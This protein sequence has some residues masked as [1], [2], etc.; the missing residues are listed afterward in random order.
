M[1]NGKRRRKKLFFFFF[2]FF[3]SPLEEI[4]ADRYAPEEKHSV[5]SCYHIFDLIVEMEK[6][7]ARSILSEWWE[8]NTRWLI[9]VLFSLDLRPARRF[10]KIISSCNAFVQLETSDESLWRS[11]LR[12]SDHDA[13]NSSIQLNIDSY[14]SLLSRMPNIKV[15]G[16][17][18]H[19]ELTKLICARLGL[20]P[21]KVITKKFSNRETR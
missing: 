4:N 20:E 6:T 7:T 10:A 17:S 3:S 13:T 2:L 15:F 1:W 14:P 12:F 21:G 9:F 16:G 18:S 19:P 5:I 8:K 11:F